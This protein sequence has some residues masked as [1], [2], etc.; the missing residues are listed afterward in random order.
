MELRVYILLQ[1]TTPSKQS[2]EHPRSL[3]S[4]LP[5]RVRGY[6][7]CQLMSVLSRH[8]YPYFYLVLRDQRYQNPTQD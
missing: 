3:D 7:S 5:F 1:D 2:Y 6:A 4:S 8:C